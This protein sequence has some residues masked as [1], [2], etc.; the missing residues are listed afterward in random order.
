M[1]K[2]FLIVTPFFFSSILK[3]QSIDGESF[4]LSTTDGIS[5]FVFEDQNSDGRFIGGQLVKNYLSL[6]LNSEEFVTFQSN[7]KKVSKKS[8][9]TIETETYALDKYS[10]DDS[11]AVYVRNGNKI[12]EIKKSEV[13]SILKL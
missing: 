10:W 12:G 7:L 4:K 1:K 11:L 3:A 5:S 13:K 9:Y 2:L 6:K 8:E